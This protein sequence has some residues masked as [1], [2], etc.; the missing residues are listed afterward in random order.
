MIDIVAVNDSVGN[1]VEHD[2]ATMISDAR[3]HDGFQI[4]Y[5][6][7]FKPAP[8]LFKNSK[9]NASIVFN[10]DNQHVH[11]VKQISFLSRY[12]Q[13]QINNARQ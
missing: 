8:L 6:M 13:K 1:L 12:V 9:Y 11:V 2:C 7:A 4:R 5:M 3:Q 10:Y